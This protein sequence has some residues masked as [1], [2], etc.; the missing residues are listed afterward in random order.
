VDVPV[1]TA[2]V[3]GYLSAVIEG[4]VEEL[5]AT[6]QNKRRPIP[7]MSEREADEVA[8][9]GEVLRWSPTLHYVPTG[10]FMYHHLALLFLPSVLYTLSFY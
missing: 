7:M 6:K 1:R 10:D 4:N 2:L 8:E 3:D 9:H 5:G